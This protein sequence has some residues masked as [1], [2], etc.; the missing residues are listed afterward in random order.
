MEDTMKTEESC[1]GYGT[2][3]IVCSFFLGG[4]LGAAVIL[5]VAPHAGKGTRQQIKSTANEFKGKAEDQYA[6]VKESVTSAL[7]HGKGLVT[8]KKE[9]IAKAVQEGIA[10]Y[11]KG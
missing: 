11:K 1:S 6:H 10:E 7:E 5:L 8:E 3:S 4:L 9:R 2:C